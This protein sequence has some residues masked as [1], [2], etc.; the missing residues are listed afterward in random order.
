M[1]LKFYPQ[2]SGVFYYLCVV[3][4]QYVCPLLLILFTGILMKNMG[5]YQW[6]SL[7]T[8]QSSGQ[9][10]AYQFGSSDQFSLKELK[11]IFNPIFFRGILGYMSW[12]LSVVW[13]TTSVI[14]F[15]YHSYF[16]RETER[17]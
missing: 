10:E 17:S 2:V 16:S 12:W 1:F 5:D 14:G 15:I 3:C 9:S 13:F 6:T 11:A 8:G 7:F 4:L